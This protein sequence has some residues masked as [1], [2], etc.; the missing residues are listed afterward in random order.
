MEPTYEYE[1]HAQLC[2]YY[3]KRVVECN[4]YILILV[5]LLVQC[6]IN[7][8][9][10]WHRNIRQCI[11]EWRKRHVEERYRRLRVDIM[12][13]WQLTGGLKYKIIQ[14]MCV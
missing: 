1:T 13:S 5:R 6:S 3:G 9:V 7:E 4:C 14:E 8:R 10:T 11:S 12:L 2:E